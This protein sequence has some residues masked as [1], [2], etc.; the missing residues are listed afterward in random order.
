ML[1]ALL[2]ST[3]ARPALEEG[4]PERQAVCWGDRPIGRDEGRLAVGADGFDT[5]MGELGNVVADGIVESDRAPFI[6]DHRGRRC[7][8]LSDRGE[9]NDRSVRS[10][11]PL[12]STRRL[13]LLWMRR[14]ERE[15]IAHD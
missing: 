10:R 3:A 12:R 11:P 4:A 7:E 6:E 13:F 1:P 15:R 9:R 5:Q 8:H 2:V 14:S